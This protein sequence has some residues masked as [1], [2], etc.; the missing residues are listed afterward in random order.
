MPVHSEIGFMNHRFKIVARVDGYGEAEGHTQLRTVA[1]IR[2]TNSLLKTAAQESGRLLVTARNDDGELISCR[3]SAGI[4]D[5]LQAVPI[6]S[7]ACRSSS[8]REDA[9]PSEKAA[10]RCV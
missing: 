7:R 9:P 6:S 8:P 10:A 2:F 3:M 5:T 4:V 1:G